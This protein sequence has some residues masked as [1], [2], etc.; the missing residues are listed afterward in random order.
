MS[1]SIDSPNRPPMKQAMSY[2]KPVPVFIPS[3]LPSPVPLPVVLPGEVRSVECSRQEEELPPLP[4]NWR[5]IV[6]TRV[7]EAKSSRVSLASQALASQEDV[8]ENLPAGL[9][10][11]ARSVFFTPEE[12][13]PSIPKI[14]N[15]LRKPP[16]A[17]KHALRGLPTAYR[18]PTPP[19]QSHSVHRI[20]L[21][22]PSP[23]SA[24]SFD[25]ERTSPTRTRVRTV[26]QP[27]DLPSLKLSPSFH[28]E[29][30]MFS[31]N[32]RPVTA[33]WSQS[34]GTLALADGGANS[35]S[36]PWKK[37]MVDVDWSVSDYPGPEN[38]DDG[39]CCSGGF[40]SRFFSSLC[41]SN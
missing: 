2:R 21:E 22:S 38:D 12:D 23:T 39:C 30:T 41:G 11:E 27:A 8:A 24:S 7:L 34:L 17:Y 1:S 14:P 13:Q 26:Y 20:T 25:H 4:Q 3:P 28:T 5:E 37:Q 33:P 9:N 16:S 32:S 29:R 10:A 19:S 36:T 18:P 15:T 31:V 35:Y 40:F 6:H